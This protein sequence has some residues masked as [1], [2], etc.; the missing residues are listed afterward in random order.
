MH[1]LIIIAVI[2]LVIGFGIFGHLQNQR[3]RKQLSAWAQANQLQ[4]DAGRDGLMAD[5]LPHFSCLHEGSQ[6]YAYNIMRGSIKG[7]QTLAFDYHYATYSTDSKGRRRTNHHHFSAL[8]LHTNLML[9]PLFIRPER[10]LDRITEFFGYDDIDFESAQFSEEF[11]VKSPDRRWAF[12][13]IHQRTMEFLLS[14]PRFT[15]QL[16]GH[17]FIVYRAKRFRPQEFD[18]AYKLAAGVL[19]RLPASL[20][21]E[22][23]GAL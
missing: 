2:G 20:V 9:R 13:V 8:V 15:L 1:G 10:F 16:A 12:D 3:R 17:D 19:N 23:Q 18:E 5:G 14:S 11:Y 22:L 7:Q 4:F 6:R 21:R